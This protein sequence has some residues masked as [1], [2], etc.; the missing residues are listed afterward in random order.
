MKL[1]PSRMIIIFVICC[2]I[3]S[4]V[5]I[6]LGKTS[7]QDSSI[8]DVQSQK[9]EM[10]KSY[11]DESGQ[12][13]YDLHAFGENLKLVLIKND[14]LVTP[15]ADVIKRHNGHTVSR[16]KIAGLGYHTG[17]IHSKPGSILA[18]KL[19][20]GYL[21]GVILTES[22]FMT[23]DGSPDEP[24]A[25]GLKHVLTK[26]KHEKDFSESGFDFPFVK[27]SSQQ[28]T[29]RNKRSAAEKRYL[30]VML[31]ADNY[32]ATTYGDFTEQYLMSVAYLISVVMQDPSIGDIRVV[33]NVAKLMIVSGYE[34]G[35]DIVEHDIQSA[36]DYL[37]LFATWAR[38]LNNPDDSHPDH[39]DQSVLISRQV[40]G[41]GSC[42]KNGRG[43]LNG[44]C[45]PA[46]S[47]SISIASGL[48]AA[49]T[50]AHE[51]G[52]NLGLSH[53]SGDCAKGYIMN[54]VKASGGNAFSWSKCSRENL[55][56]S[57]NNKDKFK[58]L[59][60]VPSKMTFDQSKI[61]IL[62]L[63]KNFSGDDQCR[64]MYGEGYGHCGPLKSNC[65]TIYCRKSGASTCIHQ[66][67]PPLEG[68]NCGTYKW[69]KNGECVDEPIPDPINGNW[70]AWSTTFSQC[71]RNCGMGVRHR[72]RNCTD[73]KPEFF[74]KPC[75]GDSIGHFETCNTQDCPS[76]T[77]TF[78]LEQCKGR[79][80]ASTDY[81]EESAKCSLSC[82]IGSIVS[83]YGTV[84]DGTLCS[85]YKDIYDVCVQGVC[86]VVG[87]DRKLYSRK[88]F[89]RC[90]I[91]AGS[92]NTCTLVSGVYTKSHPS[93]GA[94]GAKVM[95][96]LPTGATN[97]VVKEMK[98]HFNEIG[99]KDESNNWIIPARSFSTVKYFAG[100]RIT[101]DREDS[102]YAETITIVGP[103]TEPL[104]IMFIYNYESNP[105]IQYHYYK[106][107]DT[108]DS[109]SVSFYWN[110]TIGECSETCAG[111]LESKIAKCYRA[112]DNTE[113]GIENCDR[114]TEPT[115]AEPCNTQPCDARWEIGTWSG[116]SEKC[117]PSGK[118]TRTVQCLQKV[119][120]TYEQILADNQCTGTKEKTEEDCNRKDCEP[121]WEPGAWSE[122]S[123]KKCE[124]QQTRQLYCKKLLVSGVKEDRSDSEC[125]TEKPITALVCN[126][127]KTCYIWK[128]VYPNCSQCQDYYLEAGNTATYKQIGCYKMEN[129][130]LGPMLASNNVDQSDKLK[131]VTEC[132]KN[133]WER[134]GRMFAVGKNGE[135]Y[136]SMDGHEIYNKNGKSS[137]CVDGIGGDEAVS[138]YAINGKLL[139]SNQTCF[140]V[141]DDSEVNN[142]NCENIV[143]KPDPEIKLC[144]EE[145]CKDY[146]HKTVDGG[147]CVIP[148]IYQGRSYERCVE[149]AGKLWCATTSNYDIDRQ[150]TECQEPCRQKTESGECC[151]FPFIYRGRLYNTC[152]S[153][154][155]NEP[156]WCAVTSNYDIDFLKSD[157]I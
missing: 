74:G 77:P 113:V 61:N 43:Y 119:N 111:G 141:E 116:C 10:K 88:E 46:Y 130:F 156:S 114:A 30:E 15:Y 21:S 123:R 71:P 59:Y 79:S 147:Y 52:H 22:H 153:T 57:F 80:S 127:E 115:G 90:R 108:P 44:M 40:C 70:G 5:C 1:R 107:L 62:E 131:T 104:K 33:Y 69:C 140:Y 95:F 124:G 152:I 55:Q 35:L 128:P 133:A 85:K 105:E 83:S 120:S 100:T 68:T 76:G 75:S 47:A 150:W 11:R 82:R 50:M 34:K 14:G 86:M 28:S 36:L 98:L 38:Q 37:A 32:T 118:R 9:I 16:E 67:T 134:A 42:S 96:T 41:L 18:V 151:S 126:P 20:D 39:F 155:N 145:V 17:Y 29:T 142:N 53:D 13:F 144:C 121:D 4:I 66:S 12:I 125:I 103:T 146:C 65:K 99:V 129:N 92:G 137:N 91:C 78:R 49:L 64:L 58:C 2:L 45:S 106:R 19:K 132:N 73:P 23:I 56:T 51:T 109:G 157:C 97:V 93:L 3:Q 27:L 136:S 122:C 149:S 135:C 94:A 102:K 89:D 26:Q 101:Y 63:T 148:F 48:H 112:D 110:Y 60:D 81:F 54:T 7:I 8:S 25:S 72:S 87:C 31:V 154:K 143:S 24:S 6:S 139:V 117:G 84:K 138:V